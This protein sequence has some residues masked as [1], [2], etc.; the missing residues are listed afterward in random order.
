ME[1]E[2]EALDKYMLEL[3]YLM[4]ANRQGVRS[5]KFWKIETTKRGSPGKHGD[6]H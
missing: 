6:H 1:K 3:V 4:L 2:I 5:D